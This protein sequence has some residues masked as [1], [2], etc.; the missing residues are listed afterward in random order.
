[1]RRFVNQ[2]GELLGLRLPRKQSNLAA[3]GDS[4]GRGDLLVEF[5]LDV[6]LCEEC[7][8]PVAVLAHFAGDV[9]LK[10]RQVRA[11]G[12]AEVEDV[13][14]TEANQHGRWLRVLLLLCRVSLPAMA[15]DRRENLNTFLALLHKS[16]K[17]VPCAN[18]RY[19]G[20]GRALSGDLQNV[21]ERIR[22]ETR[23][24]AE[25]RG[26][27]F[28]LARLKLLDEVIHGLLDKLLGGVVLLAVALLV[29]RL[30]AVL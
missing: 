21:P 14:G 9:V 29:R 26:Q 23:H 5:Q 25:I 12:L 15:D 4:K 18:A 6:L 3:V 27:S 17:L 11:Y 19:S 22:M 20:G 24:R 13:D 2:R 28:A 16:A 1:M 8:H 7:N 10:L 30:A